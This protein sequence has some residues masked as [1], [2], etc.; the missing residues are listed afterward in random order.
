[1]L[2]LPVQYTEIAASILRPSP[3]C[4]KALGLEQGCSA[5]PPVSGGVNGGHE[6]KIHQGQLQ[7]T[8]SGEVAPEVSRITPKSRADVRKMFQ[9]ERRQL[10]PP[11]SPGPAREQTSSGFVLRRIVGKS[12]DPRNRGKQNASGHCG[13]ILRGLVP[14]TPDARS[15]IRHR[16]MGKSPDP[17]KLCEVVGT[18]EP[19]LTQR[20]RGKS[21]GPRKTREML[22]PVGCRDEEVRSRSPHL[23]V[24]PGR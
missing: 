21:P 24:L 22:G 23:A 8:S 18:P 15:R 13:G 6:S 14:H 16:L 10:Q 20:I 1:M 11:P 12:P 5:V 4:D 7:G 9:E 17:R 3:L 19:R 2:L